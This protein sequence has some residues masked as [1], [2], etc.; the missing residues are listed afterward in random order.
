MNTPIRV[1][2]VDDYPLD[3]ELV[4]DALEHEHGGFAV[5]EAASREE[6]EAVLAAGSFDLVLSDFNILGFEG[7]QVL[8]AVQRRGLGIPVVIVTGTGSEEVAVEAMKRGAADYVIKTPQHIQRL[9]M[10]IHAALERQRLERERR[11][12][13]AQLRS[14]YENA[15]EGIHRSSLEGRYLSVNPAMARIYGYESPEAMLAQ[16]HDIASQV[17]VRPSDRG[18]L[19]QAISEHGAVERFEVPNYR[20]D[21]SIIWIQTSARLV[22]APGQEP[23][24]EGFTTDI[25]ERKLAEHK[26]ERQLQ[27]LSALRSI[28]TAIGSNFDLQIILNILIA[29]VVEELRVDA[30]NIL[31]LDPR[32]LILEN[33]VTRGFRTHAIEKAHVRLGE[34][35]AGRAA[36]EHRTVHIANLAEHTASPFVSHLLAGEDFVSYIG[37]PL[38]AKGQVKGVLEVFQRSPLAPDQEWLDFMHTLAQQAAIAINDAMVFANLQQSNS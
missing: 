38:I 32:L 25:T 24:L 23:F 13:E 28:D 29:H 7:L 2:Y 33:T 5:T 22:R 30:A 19:L 12:A 31:L 37:V 15:V 8:D 4:R 36:L 11:R 21:G 17:Y 18:A 6:F 26:L 20:R 16:I 9:P 1:L 34:S 35:F 3:R 14:L 27:R 10:T